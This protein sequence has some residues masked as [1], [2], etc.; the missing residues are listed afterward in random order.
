M[1]NRS[2]LLLTCMFLLTFP[3]TSSRVLA[4]GCCAGGAGSPIA[5]GASQGVLNEK[6]FEVMSSFQHLSSDK[7][8]SGSEYSEQYFDRYNSN[9]TYNRL[10]YGLSKKFTFSM[11]TGYFFNKTQIGLN[12]ADTVMSSGFGDLILFPRYNVWSKSNDSARWEITL[13][14]GFK[15]P[16]G[17]HNDSMLVFTN[18][19]NGRQYFT[20]SPPLV[21]VTTGSNDLIL[22]GFF[23]RDFPRKSFQVF[24]MPLY[25]RKGWNSLG[26]KFGDYASL[27]LFASQNFKNGL[28]LTMQLRADMVQPIQHDPDFD[29]LALYNID[30]ASTGSRKLAFLP[31]VNYSRRG[32]TFFIQNEF[33]L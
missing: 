1:K 29:L 9:Y 3:A 5:G 31:Q 15:L 17:S 26:Q 12:A 33:P 25:I 20:A 21:Q 23:L 8:R 10:S 6:Q 7:F 4:Q 18:P 11:E 14:L 30:A 16:L 2:L 28:A 32:F 19:V 22:Y 24:A 27:G 13:G